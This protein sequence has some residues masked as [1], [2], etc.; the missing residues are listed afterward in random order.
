[1]KQIENQMTWNDVTLYQFTELQKLIQ[2]EDETER[3]CAIAEL[4]LGSAITDLPIH[5]FNEA[6]KQLD[7]LK[8]EI[9]THVPPKKLEI[10]GRKYFIDCLL[11]NITT[12]QYVDFMNHQKTNNMANMLS[13]FIIPDGHKY[14]DGYDMQQ[15]IDDI[16]CLPIPN[17]SDI[18]FFFSRQLQLFMEIFQTY[19]IRK[20]KKMRKIPKEQREEMIKAVIHST[21]LVSYLTS[22]NSVK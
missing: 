22:L 9:P 1:M 16:W 3:V 2:I 15:V 18:A 19:S 14:N 7:F 12:A 21:D 10:N 4:L 8:T 5:D 20:I 11:G 6:V 13:V 17:A